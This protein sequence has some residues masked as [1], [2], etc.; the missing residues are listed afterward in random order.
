MD[1]LKQRIALQS[2]QL[3]H[4]T[5]MQ[6]LLKGAPCQMYYFSLTF[7]FGSLIVSMSSVIS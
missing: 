2:G 4:S 5:K 7:L 3:E 1:D 6:S